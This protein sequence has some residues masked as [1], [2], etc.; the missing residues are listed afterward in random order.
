MHSLLTFHLLSEKIE[1]GKA[2]RPPNPTGFPESPKH[3]FYS[4]LKPV[5]NT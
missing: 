5:V 3:K 4:R 2:W 1:L